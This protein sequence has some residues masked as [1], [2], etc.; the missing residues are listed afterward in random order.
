MFLMLMWQILGTAISLAPFVCVWVHGCAHALWKP[1]PGVSLR[2]RSL[3]FALLPGCRATKLSG[4][5]HLH[6]CLHPALRLQVLVGVS[7]FKLKS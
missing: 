7:R 4:S 1:E 3:I 2:L 6:P 5:S